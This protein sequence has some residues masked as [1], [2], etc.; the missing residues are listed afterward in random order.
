MCW[1]IVRLIYIYFTLFPIAVAYHQVA[2]LHRL[3]CSIFV[4]F[5]FFFRSFVRCSFI[6]MV[7]RCSKCC[8]CSVCFTFFHVM[9]PGYLGGDW[10]W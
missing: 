7:G 9:A 2:H 4:F 5:S 3:T 6:P 1:F 8:F 10:R